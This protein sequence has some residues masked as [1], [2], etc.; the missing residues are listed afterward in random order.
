MEQKAHP[1][2]P[3]SK[4]LTHRTVSHSETVSGFSR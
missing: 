4:L 2:E 3:S 1:E